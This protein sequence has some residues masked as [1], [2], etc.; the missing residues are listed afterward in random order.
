[1]NKERLEF[2]L[3]CPTDWSEEPLGIESEAGHDDHGL[4][5]QRVG[6]VRGHQDDLEEV[7]RS[8]LLAFDLDDQH[9]AVGQDG[10]S[11]WK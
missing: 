2:N 9:E 4:E 10:D 5:H 7:D 6:E 1:M 11:D 8:D 3:Q